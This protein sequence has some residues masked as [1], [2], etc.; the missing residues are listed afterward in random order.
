MSWKDR[1]AAIIWGNLAASPISD[2]A[3]EQVVAEAIEAFENPPS[4]PE[5]K[6][7]DE[8]MTSR[9]EKFSDLRKAAKKWSGWEKGVW[10]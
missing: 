7:P 8:P 10:E 5:A 9:G 6:K 4:A 2:N 1:I 3:K